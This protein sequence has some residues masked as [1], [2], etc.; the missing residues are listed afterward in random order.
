[1]FIFPFSTVPFQ[2]IWHF[3]RCWSNI[4]TNRSEDTKPAPIAR[5][6]SPL[7]LLTCQAPAVW[8]A[9]TFSRYTKY[10]EN[11]YYKEEIA[12]N[13]KKYHFKYNCFK[14]CTTREGLSLLSLYWKEGRLLYNVCLLQR[15]LPLSFPFLFIGDSDALTWL[16]WWTSQ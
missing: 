1:M 3:S 12:P 16:Y 11:K 14:Y 2:R 10:D 6:Q 13:R 4:T 8:E 15:R 9:G 5:F 7:C